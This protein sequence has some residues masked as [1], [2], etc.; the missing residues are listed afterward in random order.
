MI[1]VVV[2]PSD[3]F[4]ASLDPARGPSRSKILRGGAVVALREIFAREGMRESCS[5]EQEGVFFTVEGREE[6]S[7][8]YNMPEHER[9]LGD[10]A[11]FRKAKDDLV[12]CVRILAEHGFPVTLIVSPRTLALFVRSDP[13][14]QATHAE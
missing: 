4:A 5:A 6:V 2:V 3:R 11:S 10:A 14:P 12:R 8:Q 9:L 1:P 7:V 13:E